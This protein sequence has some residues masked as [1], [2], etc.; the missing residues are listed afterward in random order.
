[1]TRTENAGASMM[2]MVKCISCNNTSA[3]WLSKSNRVLFQLL[4]IGVTK[5]NH[6]YLG[7]VGHNRVKFRDELCHLMNLE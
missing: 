6:K 5:R 7:K 1:M 4:H 3:D 2:L